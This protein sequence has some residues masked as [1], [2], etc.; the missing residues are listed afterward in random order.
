MVCDD[1]QTYDDITIPAI[2]IPASA[3]AALERVLPSGSDGIAQSSVKMNFWPWRLF[4]VHL[5]CTSCSRFGA[6]G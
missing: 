1:D 5:E 3:G 2:M 4:T 6:S